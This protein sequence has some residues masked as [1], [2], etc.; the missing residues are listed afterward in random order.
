MKYIIILIV[1]CLVQ[2][3]SKDV[4]VDRVLKKLQLSTRDIFADGQSTI[5]IS[6]ELPDETSTDRRTVIFLTTAGTFT[7]SGTNKL[8]TGAEFENGILIAKA[9]IKAPLEP[10]NM[11]I[12][13]KPGFDSELA[14]YVLSDSITTKPSVPVSL[15]LE[16]SSFGIAANHLSEVFIRGNLRNAS[17]RFVSRGYRV[18]LEDLVSFTPAN[19]QF[20]GLQPVT[21]DSSMI[22]TYYSAF[23]YP[24]GTQIKIRGTL[25][26]ANAQKTAITDSIYITINQ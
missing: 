13:V 16:P 5:S 2:S 14:D 18:I 12:S 1:F 8:A 21:S 6:V 11:V 23:A 9:T 20:R 26:D 3:C 22:S 25:L 17:G 10:G 19:G 15:D 4:K 7:S 24:I